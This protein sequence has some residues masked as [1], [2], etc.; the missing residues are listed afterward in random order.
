LY[1][2]SVCL[3]TLSGCWLNWLRF[4]PVHPAKLQFITS[5]R[6]W[7]PQCKTSAVL[8]IQLICY[9]YREPF[10]LGHVRNQGSTGSHNFCPFMALACWKLCQSIKCYCLAF[11]IYILNLF[12]FRNSK[13]KIYHCSEC[14]SKKKLNC[15]QMKIGYRR[16]KGSGFKTFSK[17]GVHRFSIHFYSTGMTWRKISSENQQCKPHHFLMQFTWCY[18]TDTHFCA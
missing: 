10:S 9:T 15:V 5:N 12:V 4:S 1:L 14:Y 16:H 17:S 8:V 13:H 6:I 7:F 11:K 2:G 3:E 18:W